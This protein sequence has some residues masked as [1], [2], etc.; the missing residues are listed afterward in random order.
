MP[1]SAPPVLRASALFALSLGVLA[2]LPLPAAALDL[3]PGDHICIIGNTTA[4]RMQHHGWLETLIHDRFPTHQ[5]VFRNLGYSADEIGGYTANPNFNQRLRS[6]D[7]GTADQWLFGQAPIPQPKKL[8]ANA[9]VRENR[10]ELVNTRPDVIFAFFGYNESFAGE[11]GLPNFKQTLAE[12]IK[13]LTS[14]KYNGKAPPRLVIF[15]PIAHENLN[16]PNLPDGNENNVRL[17]MYTQAMG[18]VCREHRIEFVDLFGPTLE[19]FNRLD[20]PQTINGIHLNETGDKLVAEICDRVLFGQAPARDAGKLGSLRLAV[21][22]KNAIFHEHYRATDGYSTFGDRAF[23]RFTDGQTNYEVLQRELEII[24]IMTSNRDAAVWAVAQ[25]KPVKIDD[26]NVPPFIPVITNKP[27]P[28]PDKSHVFLGGEE[29]IGKMTIGQGL[30]VELFASEEQF[31]NLINP[32]QMA[33]DTR[34]RL[35]VAT[36]PMY[37]HWKPGEP[38]HDALLILE[39]TNKDGRADKCTPFAEDLHNPTGF[40]F[41]G[42]GVFVACGPSVYFLKD[43][44]GD[45]RYDIKERVLHGLDTADTHH[46]ANSF[47][48]DPG[49][50]L[51]FQEGTFHH[52]QIESPWGPPRRVAN[53]A[54]FRYEPRTQKID[55]HVSYGFANPHGNAWDRW[56]QNIVVDGTGAVPYHG[57]LFSG[58]VNFPNKHGGTPSVYQQRTRPCPAI[59]FLSSSHFTEDFRDNLLVQNVIGFQGILRYKS[60]ENQSTIGASELEPMLSSSDPNFRPADLETAPDGALYFIDWQNPIIGHMQH[61]LRDPSRDKL[62]GRVYRVTQVDRPLM[63]PVP[64]AGRSARELVNL[65]TH[66]DD[67]VRYR[68]R[69]ELSDRPTPE[70]IAAL[71]DWFPTLNKSAANYERHRM[72]ALWAY[73]QHNVVNA[74]LLEQVLASPE[75][76]AR[77]AAVKVLCAWRDRVTNLLPLLHRAAA[78]PEGRVRLEAIRAASFIPL[79]E[80]VEVVLIAGELP[81]DPYLEHITRETMRTLQ[82]LV[83]L[84]NKSGKRIPFTTE[85]GARYY[86]KNMSNEQLLAEDRDRLVLLE[87]LNRPGIQDPDRAAAIRDLAQLTKQPAW[88]VVMQTIQSL[89][90]KAANADPTVIFDLV[91]QLSGLAPAEL[92]AARGELEALA[93]DAKQPIFR[94]MAYV[95]LMNIDGNEERAW[96]A[97]NQSPA[98]LI[99]FVNAL[100]LISDL[101]LRA[102]VYEKV[103]PLLTELPAHLGVSNKPGTEGRYV[104]I[105]L[106]GRGTLTLAEVEV[107]ANG[108]NVARQGRASQKNTSHGGEAARGIDGNKAENYGAGG[109]T[110]SEENTNQPYWEVDLGQDYPLEK[111][112]IYN[113]KDGDLGDRLNNHTLEVLNSAREVIFKL[114]NQ[115]APQSQAQVDLPAGGLASRIR[116]AAMLA[117]TAVRGKEEAAAQALTK[118]VLDDVDRPAAIQALQRLPR[119]AWP[120]AAAPDLIARLLPAIKNIPAAERTSPAALDLLEYV[121]ALATLLPADAAKGVR[122]Q[123]EELGVRVIKLNTVFEKMAYDKEVLVVKAGKPVEFVL[124]NT[125]LMPHNFV[126]V[127]PGSLEEIG[128]LSE[129]NAQKP[130]FAEKQF[131]PDSDKVLAKSA[132]LQPRSVTRVSF[133]AP[134]QPGVYPYVC[135]YPGHWRRMY[136]ALYVVPDL[137]DYQTDPEGYLAANKIEPVDPLLKDRRPR[138]EWKLAELAEEVNALAKTGGRNLSAGREL[139]KVANCASCHK[140][141]GQGAEFGPDLTKLDPKWKPADIL[142]H[143]LEPSKKIDDKYVTWAMELKSGQTLT[144]MI[145]DETIDRVRVIENPLAK[146][147]TRDIRPRE[148]AERQKLPTSMMPKGLLDKLSRDEI[149]DLMAYILSQGDAKHPVYHGEGHHHH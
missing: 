137:N 118:F 54:V 102:K 17:K 119:D 36:W 103:L 97:A 1:R 106:P 28:N 68:A 7:F 99:D 53:G 87:L 78:D 69:I 48:F 50:A 10:F 145:L 110:H 86:L 5:L 9:P 30:K 6:M 144:G 104:R 100:P 90:A 79:P 58:H 107:Y 136:G 42:G 149:L 95:S 45:D 111:I 126:I 96:R 130:G 27:G 39:D 64:V 3:Q 37:P 15:S 13:H 33:F 43:T 2:F 120:K 132:L 121:D 59:E 112:V 35:W 140:F 113:R 16:D 38:M 26:S 84:A 20:A 72:E 129:E 56:G 65:L 109:Q 73:Q 34:G 147:D 12:M 141:A 18:E 138:T 24:D 133:N 82:P 4:E 131:V 62:H 134:D 55:V 89:D 66:S 22:D 83:E 47:T 77:A 76:H 60:Q 19:A 75:S 94:Q 67:R 143:L 101:G 41:W 70:V 115:P 25:G 44:N 128:M 31:K 40:E 71:E 124:E 108:Q 14:Q 29:A 91:R 51:Y 127:R 146:A 117:I 81:S 57:T 61:N 74:A 125:D 98:S 142:D 21:N 80:A 23:L 105:S 122:N 49:G 85:V 11:A 139:F 93:A 63:E 92:A 88:R 32:V 8:N 46:T 116:R 123:L 148:I 52:T 135:T 114:E